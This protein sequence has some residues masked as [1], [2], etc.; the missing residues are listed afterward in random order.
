[1]GSGTVT[2]SNSSARA[3]GCEMAG[4]KEVTIA[5]VEGEL[6]GMRGYADRHGW[7]VAWDPA[8][9][10]LTVDGRHPGAGT[11]ARLHADVTDYRAVPPAWTFG[12]D[13]DSTVARFPQPGTVPENIQSIFHSNGVI[14]AP[15]SRLAYANHGGPHG[16]WG[17]PANWLQITGKV[18]A[19]TLGD[20]L[21]HIVLHL[22]YSPGWKK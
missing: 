3:V 13:A 15:F 17:G 6:P 11:A 4:S 21:A 18:T 1:M 8:H 12:I 5:T 20:M 19:K 2:S 10:L 22:K 7:R 14:C 16:D 9:L